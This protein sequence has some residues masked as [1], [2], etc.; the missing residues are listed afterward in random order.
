MSESMTVEQAITLVRCHSAISEVLDWRHEAELVLAD[1]VETLQRRVAVRGEL[2]R[3]LEASKQQ[4]VQERDTLQARVAEFE[5]I[6]ENV[7]EG[8][9][10]ADARVLRESNHKLADEVEIQKEHVKKFAALAEAN[11]D[12]CD[13][14]TKERDELRRRVAAVE[15]S[16]ENAVSILCG[17]NQ[18]ADDVLTIKAKAVMKRVSELETESV[19][20]R[21][22]FDVL[23]SMSAPTEQDAEKLLARIKAEAVREA[24][25]KV[26][27]NYRMCHEDKSGNVYLNITALRDY[28]NQIEG[29]A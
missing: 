10:P 1:E 14:V 8:C 7:P 3:A 12:L 4:V 27:G 11:A 21:Y 28:A 22:K 20:L 6:C 2:C 13:R 16:A 18:P 17:H 19:S 15:R 29:G 23:I 9:T 26:V 5:A 24:C 25:D